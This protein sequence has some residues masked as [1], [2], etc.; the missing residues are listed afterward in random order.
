[1]RWAACAASLRRSPLRVDSPPLLAPRGG[2]DAFGSGPWTGPAHKRFSPVRRCAPDCP[3]CAALLGAAEAPHP[4]PTRTS[5]RNGSAPPTSRRAAWSV[6]VALVVET[7]GAAG[8]VVGGRAAKCLCGAEER[9]GTGVAHRPK[10][11]RRAQPVRA[12][13]TALARG[14]RPCEGSL[15]SGTEHRRGVDA[16]RRPPQRSAAARAPTALHARSSPEASPRGLRSSLSSARSPRSRA[17]APS[18]RR[19]RTCR[20]GGTAGWF[21][22]RGRCR[23]A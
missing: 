11:M 4:P 10:A 6:R 21:A 19:P 3:R 23:R 7:L 18:G 20:P 16:T 12:P 13:S 17:R 8:K 5:A 9:R 1:M 14:C 2:C 15:R 22:P